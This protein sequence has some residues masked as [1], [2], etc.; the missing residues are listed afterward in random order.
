MTKKQLTDRCKSIL[1][2]GQ[3][4]QADHDFLLAVF[5]MH[6]DFEQKKG[7]GIKKFTVKTTQYGNK[8][9]FIIR[10]DGTET[11][12]SFTHAINKPS[13]IYIIKKACR[14]AIRNEIAYFKYTTVKFGLDKCPFTGE[15][16]TGEN[17]HIDHYD[18]QFNEMFNIWIK[19]YDIDFLHS[20]INETKDN[21]YTTEFTDN[22]I[23]DDFVSFHNSHCKLRAVSK[24]ANLTILK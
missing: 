4:S 10:T 7:V 19:K 20:K 22:V 15:I 18:M 16:L 11:D 14:S 17:T 9:F 21:T 2:S 6:S 8:C 24:T 23:I 5:E 3:I 12:I 1:H 13:K